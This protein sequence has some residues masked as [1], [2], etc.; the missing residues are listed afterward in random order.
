MRGDLIRYTLNRILWAIPV[1]ILASSLVF[2]G[3]HFMPG[4]P[5]TAMLPERMQTERFVDLVRDQYRL[6]EPLYV[7]Y[8]H[9]MKGVATGDMGDSFM[10]NRPVFE[11]IAERLVRTFQMASLAIV[12][13]LVFS[14]PLGALSAAYKDSWIDSGSRAVAVVGMSLPDFW[15]AIMLILI[16]ARVWSQWFGAPLIPSGGFEHLSSG[17]WPWFR[18]IIGPSVVLAIGY[19]AILIRITRSSMVEALRRPFVKAAR[20]KGARERS[21]IFVHAFRNA[22]APV[23]TIAGYRMGFI[24]NGS[25]LV[26]VVFSYPGVGLLTYTSIIQND[27]PVVLGA[28]LVIV[29]IYITINFLVDVAYVVLDPRIDYRERAQ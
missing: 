3:I 6:D 12:M 18:H 7:Q 13:G 21:V 19:G 11:L 28:I 29:L 24:L 27:M 20:A 4:D 17:V 14:I 23:V 25:V 2:L 10:H 22:L 16:F 5:A 15:M 1:V 26:E 8:F 9:W